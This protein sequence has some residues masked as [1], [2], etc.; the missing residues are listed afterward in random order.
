L[1][2][3]W[4]LL[5][6]T[7]LTASYGQFY[8]TPAFYKIAMQSGNDGKLKSSK[9]THYIVGVE[10]LLAENTKIT[11]E[12][13]YKDMKDLITRPSDEIRILLEKEKGYAEGVEFSIHKKMSNRY[14]FLLSYSYAV[15]KRNNALFPN[16]YFADYDRR[17]TATVEGI[18]KISNV[19]QLG[20][21]FHVASGNPYTP[22]VGR[23]LVD[24]R[25]QAIEGERNSARFPVYHKLDMRVDRRFNFEKWNL[26][27]YIDTWNVYDRRNV[28]AYTWNEDYSQ[29]KTLYQF[30]IIPMVGMNAEF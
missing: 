23:Q 5:D 29:R 18:Y 2:V 11:T 9:A 3:S 10:H 24:G 8:Q 30:S 28:G 19:W 13:F 6:R 4:R 14:Y 27:T 26:T 16:D 22:V 7:T 1:G 25:W 12:L 20:T 21:K 15:A 17:H